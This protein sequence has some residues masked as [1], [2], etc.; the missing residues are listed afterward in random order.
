MDGNKLNLKLYYLRSLLS[1]RTYFVVLRKVL[2]EPS[3]YPEKE[4]K[5]KTK[6]LKDN[7]LWLIRN[8]EVNRYYNTYGLDIVGFRNPS[9]FIPF[10]R[11]AI[12]R[13]SANLKHIVDGYN[14]YNR[15]CIL[16][17]KAL[18]AA[19]I[20]ETIGS[21]Y[22]V[23][24]I[25]NTS[26]RNAYVFRRGMMP[27]LTLLEE[28]K[29]K[30]TILKKVNGECGDGIYLLENVSGAWYVNREKID[31]NNFLQNIESSEYII[32]DKVVQHEVLDAINPSCVNT[33]RFVTIVNKQ[34]KAQIF[35]HFLRVGAGNAVKDN[36][37]TGGYAVNILEDGTLSG[38]AI[39]H[40]DTIW[41][42]PDTGV[43]FDGYKLPFWKEVVDLVCRAHE[44]MPEIK[45]IGWDVAITPDGP[46]LIE[47][48]DN[49]EICG[50]QDT[51]GGLKK[52]WQELNNM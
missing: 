1:I 36:R 25:A 11:F 23:P 35:A 47:G 15:I 18:F 8:H 10:R 26:G 49:W 31:I 51:A 43:V 42:H 32:Q 38:R 24:V 39:G 3:V 14:G 52:K 16:R 12:E 44:Q 34:G 5:S 4:R 40:R 30:P 6:R 45:S 22:A 28:R 29:E 48:N 2:N 33:I 41:K 37:A 19:F 27:V 9:D 21:Q 50:P 7:L 20:R 13:D 17:D 46:I